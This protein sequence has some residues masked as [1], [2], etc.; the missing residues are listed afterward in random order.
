MY[1]YE[2]TTGKLLWTYTAKNPTPEGQTFDQWPLYPMFIANG[3]IY[4]IHTEHSGFE[5]SLPPEAPIICL[6]ATT[7]ELVWRADGLFR[8]THWGGYP[9]I[10]DSIIAAMNSYDQQ[11]YAIGKGP[12]SVTVEAPLAGVNVADTIV[13]R[14]NVNDVSP[15]TTQAETKLRFPNGVPAVADSNMTAWMRYVYQQLPKPTNIQGVEVTINVIDANGNYRNIGTTTS[16]ENGFFSLAWQPDIS[17]KY[18]VNAV[19]AGTRCLLW[20]LSPNSILCSRL[21]RSNSS[22][23]HCLNFSH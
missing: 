7:G 12:T 20:L 4:V 18:T 16:D 3:M 9:I 2:A 11:I 15:G 5:Q 23:N 19:F 6:N 14:G 10:G 17:G 8:G 22:P 1:C 13:I 21:T